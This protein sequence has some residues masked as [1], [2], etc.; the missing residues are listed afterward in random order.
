[1][2]CRCGLPVVFTMEARPGEGLVKGAGV[3]V[4]SEEL[5]GRRE[6]EREGDEKA[7]KK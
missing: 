3:G 2:T 5:R 4:A 7:M 1:M 6:G